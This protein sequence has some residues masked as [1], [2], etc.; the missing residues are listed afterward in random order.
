M[1][2]QTVVPVEAE[3]AA[4]AAIN[5]PLDVDSLKQFCRD[6]ERLF[7]INPLLIF[8]QWQAQGEHRYLFSGQNISQE[9]PF[10]FEFELSV[11]EL[12][13]GFNIHYCNGIK[14]STRIKIEAI[15]DGSRLTIIDSYEGLSEEEREAR[16]N[17]VDKSLV[18]WARYLQKFLLSW[19]KWSRF[20]LWR[21]YM[22]RIWQPMNP[23]GRRVTYMLL[24]ITAFEIALITLGVG[25]YFLE[26]R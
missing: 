25:I 3:D 15:P 6:T 17:E 21:W 23:S 20:G 16:I 26:Y 8:N 10:D 12:P 5:T 2:D 14:N 13:D 9:T 1:N 4:W 19:K 24:W 22:H 7:R 11:D 18:T